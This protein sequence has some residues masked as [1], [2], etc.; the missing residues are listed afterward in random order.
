MKAFLR[1]TTLLAIAGLT[2]FFAACKRNNPGPE[3]AEK[4]Q[5]DKL[6]KTWNIVSATLDGTDRTADFSNFQLE[7]TGT[8]PSTSDKGPYN[9]QV[10]GSRP[11]PSPWPETGTWSFGDDATSQIIR[12]D[13]ISI[14]YSI[15]NNELTLQFACVSC[16]YS[17]ARTSAVNGD[18]Q[19][20]LN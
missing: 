4:Q 14:L 15:D 12:N 5:L 13:D 10:S 18:W 16:N 9:F 17:G 2:V 7:I 19:F 20:V 8:F 3:S 6:S 1:L 11:T